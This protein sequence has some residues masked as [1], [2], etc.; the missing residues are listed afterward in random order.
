MY[1]LI[2][3][4]TLTLSVRNTYADGYMECSVKYTD[5]VINELGKWIIPDGTAWKG[6][7]NFPKAFKDRDIVFYWGYS[8]KLIFTNL[9]INNYSQALPQ[10]Q[11]PIIS[12]SRLYETGSR[13]YAESWTL[14]RNRPGEEWGGEHAWTLSIQ[15]KLL[16]QT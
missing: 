2:L 1:L 9:G 13:Q 15:D 6:K 10:S 3:I 11:P 12:F 14:I 8:N 7:Y 5:P 16:V 4:T